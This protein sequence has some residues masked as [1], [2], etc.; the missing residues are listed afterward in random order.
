MT[1]SSIPVVGWVL[2]AV[3]ACGDPGQAPPRALFQVRA[4][5]AAQGVSFVATVAW[6]R[7]HVESVNCP[8]ADSEAPPSLRCAADGFEVS[9]RA[10]VS[11]LTVRAKGYAFASLPAPDDQKS[12]STIMLEPLAEAE[13]TSDYATRL[14]GNDC[15]EALEGLALPFRSDV[16]ESHSVKFH[17]RD[18]PTQPKVYFQNTRKHPLHFDFARNVLGVSGT[19]DEF[20]LD[21]YAG[22]SRSAMAGT[23]IFYPAVRGAARGAT[24]EVEAPWTLNFFPSDTLTIDQARLVH[25]LL[26]E[27]IT[28]LDWTGSVRRLVYVPATSERERDA[29]EDDWSLARAGV[30]WMSHAQ[31][32]GGLRLQPLNEGVA[33]GTLLRLTPEELATKVVSF[34]DILLLTRLPNELPL[35]GGT[36]TEEFQTPLAHVNV[37]ARSRGTPNLAYPQAFQDEVVA[38]NIGELVRFEV[39]PSGFTLEKTSL[40]EAEAFW[41]GSQRERFV[42][43]FDTSA[44]GIFA[45]A[46]VG[47]AD[48]TRIGAK[49]ANLA[50]LS[51]VLGPH[52]PD[53]GLAVPF[54]YY[55]EFM[56]SAETSVELCDAA[57]R[58]C[59]NTWREAAACEHARELCIPGDL[60]ET[61]FELAARVIDDP[62]F[63]R[64]TALREAV[65]ANLRYIIENTPVS[66][67]FGGLL[68]ARVTEVFADAK[69]R[70][71][72]STNAEDLPHFSGAGLYDSHGAYGSGT[73]AA[74]R[75]VG[76]V[77]ASVW[78]FRGF[79]ERSLWNI[80]HLAVR[81]GAAINEAFTDE[82][83]NGV[84]ITQNIA[85]PTVYGMYVN[86]QL[87]EAAVTNPGAG[88]LPEIFSILADTGYQLV[89]QRYSSLSPDA[90]ILSDGEMRSLYDA[91]QRASAHFSALYERQVIL[92]IE[93]KL[94][95]QHEIV[96]KQARPYSARR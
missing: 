75:V 34:R 58:D 55:D 96:F 84:L 86:V 73:K 5:D 51:H 12:A 15:L 85:D 60:P 17:I 92:D 41:H 71:R 76:K 18:L 8:S 4:S 61:L 49:A 91:G 82:L 38:S 32:A 59:S 54:Y 68:D 62:D 22:T 42:P 26:E 3:T 79:E 87:G 20:A 72:S 44:T 10:Q 78:T 36:I 47:F 40:Q 24:P 11:D 90:A 94:T 16:G 23:L 1:P 19:A 95:P 29:A 77:F 33:Y 69:V 67:E 6:A 13:T 65:L 53:K 50:E 56:T 89:R 21:T 52:A 30:G 81:M 45:F 70:I 46:D 74:S 66:D 2:L 63:N 35:V 14:D 64:D 31:L 88:Q 27:R 37:A 25:R 83:A 48:S 7:G 93:F 9:N 80:D 28:C 57:A 39:A 43:S